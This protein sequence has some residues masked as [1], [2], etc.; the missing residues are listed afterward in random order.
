MS[1]LI[2]IAGP[3]T[4]PDPVSNTRRAIDAFNVLVDAGF[5]PF[6]PHLTLFIDIIHQQ[7][8]SFWYAYDLELLERCDVLLRLSGDSW[9][10][11]REVEFAT[12]HGIP[13]FFGTAEEF[14]DHYSRRSEEK[15]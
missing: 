13:V 3:Y 9:G 7:S 10:A 15:K 5:T 6:V 14:V 11:D 4:D 8:A 12:D 2:Y 1:A